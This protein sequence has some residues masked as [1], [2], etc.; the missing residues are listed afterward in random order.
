MLNQQACT[1]CEKAFVNTSMLTLHRIESH[2]YNPVDAVFS[3]ENTIA[4]NSQIQ[5]ISENN[6]KVVKCEICGKGFSS[7]RTL[8]DH[9]K[10][11]HDKSNHIKCDQCDFSTFE[12]YRLKK[13][14]LHKHADKTKFPCDQCSFATNHRHNLIK[15][16]KNVHQDI[17]SFEC[18]E[19]TNAY[20]TKKSLAFHLLKE[21]NILYKYK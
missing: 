19:C 10:Q 21:H 7:N 12:P 2:S 20:K 3:K 15:H 18:S 13:H 5:V 6:S 17:S 9:H 8:S 16:V 14:K 1:Q 4:P 11:F